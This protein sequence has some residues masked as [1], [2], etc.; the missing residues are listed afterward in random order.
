MRLADSAIVLGQLAVIVTPSRTRQPGAS[1]AALPALGRLRAALFA[2]SRVG[3]LA[4]VWLRLDRRSG[5]YVISCRLIRSSSGQHKT[6]A[7]GLMF[8][9]GL[10]QD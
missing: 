9:D 8:R 2:L 10:M 7:R 6:I 1:L 5:E 4:G 3:S